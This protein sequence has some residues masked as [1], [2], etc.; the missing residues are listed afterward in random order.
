MSVVGRRRNP[1]LRKAWPCYQKAAPLLSF[2]RRGRLAARVERDKCGRWGRYHL[3]RLI[4]RYGIDAKLFDWSDEIM[5]MIMTV[6]RVMAVEGFGGA[7]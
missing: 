5:A 3:H 6:S 4:E 2:G 7:R 1:R